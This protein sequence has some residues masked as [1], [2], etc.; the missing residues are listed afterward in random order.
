MKQPR[1]WGI[2]ATAIELYTVFPPG[3]GGE[4]IRDTANIGL[5]WQKYIQQVSVFL[6]MS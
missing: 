1:D 4:L 6:T 5:V 2:K 3:F